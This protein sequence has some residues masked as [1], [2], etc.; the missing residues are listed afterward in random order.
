MRGIRLG[1]TGL[2]VS[3]VGFGGIPIQRLT[4]QEAVEVVR[5]CLDLGI[6]FLDTANGYSTSEERIGKAIAGRRD[7]LVLATKTGAREGNEVASHLALSL[8]RLG[9][10]TVDLYQFHGVSS[11]EDYRKVVA[12]G[13]P[14]EVVREAQA[15]GQ[16]RHI[17]LTSH[18]MQ[19]ALKAVQS[20]HFETI[21]FPFNFV[22]N[23][24]AQELIPVALERGLAFIAMKPLAGG[25]LDDAVLAFKYLRQ[26]PEILPI[27]G[28]ER[29]GEIEE[30]VE[31]MEGPVE[32]E[33]EE[34]D[35][36][37]SLQA[38]LGQ[39]FCRRCGYCQPCP[40]GVSIQL[41]MIIDSFIKRMPAASVFAQCAD[42]VD[43]I[44]DCTE[45][46]E[47]EEKCPYQLP[48]RDMLQE[49]A[50]LFRKEMARAGLI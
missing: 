30:I 46:G 49:H 7:G 9:V 37:R 33:P 25:A 34:R 16:V 26:F 36:I 39:R 6:T 48:I 29:A 13:G 21:M 43:G 12:P 20:G 8:E 35:R 42:V 2:T 45:C 23:E 44:A 4:E 24:A 38:E 47:C 28:I 50:E 31:I 3:A 15:S 18:S 41:M 11:D 32:L 10:E 5:H 17:G 14:L 1:K 22:A 19:I 27:P 40:E